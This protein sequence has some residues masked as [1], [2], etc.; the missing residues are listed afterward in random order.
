[1][2]QTSTTRRATAAMAFF[3]AVD[4]LARDISINFTTKKPRTLGVK[5]SGL[6]DKNRKPLFQQGFS[7]TGALSQNTRNSLLTGARNFSS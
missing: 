1:V 2:G 3:A 4:Q 6:P 7:R 5:T